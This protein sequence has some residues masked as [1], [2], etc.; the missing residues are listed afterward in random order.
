[1]SE[2]FILKLVVAGLIA[3]IQIINLFEIGLHKRGPLVYNL[4][5]ALACGIALVILIWME[6]NKSCDMRESIKPILQTARALG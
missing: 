4:L 2:A 5:R 6:V 3:A 1:M